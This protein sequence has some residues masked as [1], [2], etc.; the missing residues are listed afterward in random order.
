MSGEVLPHELAHIVAFVLK[1]REPP[2]GRTWKHVCQ[3][4]GGSGKARHQ[5]PTTPARRSRQYL[6]ATSNGTSVWL[7]ATRHARAQA[8]NRYLLANQLLY[9]QGRWRWKQ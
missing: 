8:G 4:L 9:F 5:L 3:T 6:Y 7:G 2:H 1:R